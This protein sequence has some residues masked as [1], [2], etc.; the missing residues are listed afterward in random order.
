MYY[1]QFALVL[2]LSTCLSYGQKDQSITSMDFVTILNGN[3]K[4]A[5]FYYENNWKVLREMAVKKGYITSFKLLKEMNKDKN[6]FSIV[7]STSYTNSLQFEKREEHFQELIKAKGGLKLLNEKQPA[8]F[9][10][11]VYSKDFIHR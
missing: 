5:L 1:K 10:K 4:E 11:T 3:D 8:E 2:M 6:S 9:R 7:L